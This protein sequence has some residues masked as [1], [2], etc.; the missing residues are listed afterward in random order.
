MS[1]YNFHCCTINY[2]R[3]SDFKQHKC[4]PSQFPLPGSSPSGFFRMKSKCG[5]GLS[6]Y[7]R[8]RVLFQAPW[9]LENSFLLGSSC[10]I[11]FFLLATPEGLLSVPRDHLQF[12]W[13]PCDKQI[14]TQMSACCQTWGAFLQLLP[15][16]N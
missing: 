8:F 16:V 7:L 10:N 4:I 5:Q 13:P 11:L 1:I 2:H 12:M 15:L 14:I 9:L 6:A 3:S